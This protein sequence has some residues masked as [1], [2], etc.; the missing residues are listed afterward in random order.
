MQKSAKNA[1]K[2]EKVQNAKAMRKW[3]QNSHSITS[4]YR[5][6]NFL[7]F[8]IFKHCIRIALPSIVRWQRVNWPRNVHLR[9]S[10]ISLCGLDLEIS[11]ARLKKSFARNF[12]HDAQSQ[13]HSRTNRIS[14]WPKKN[15]H[16]ISNRAT[17]KKK[18]LRARIFGVWHRVNGRVAKTRGTDLRKS[19]RS[20]VL[21][22]TGIDMWPA[23]VS[24]VGENN[25]K[26]RYGVILPAIGKKKGKIR[27]V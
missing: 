4:H 23:V 25:H 6:N 14:Y 13:Y 11:Y 19:A 1:E 15:H 9:M 16:W 22:D 2:C 27:S 17:K 26:T 8:R 3:N 7:H 10:K 5:N 20:F 12:R 24:S 21:H 18:T